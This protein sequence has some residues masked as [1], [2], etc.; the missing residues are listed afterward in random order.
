MTFR[1]MSAVIQIKPEEG[2]D[3]DEEGTYILNSLAIKNFSEMW[4]LSII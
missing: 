2:I 1:M 4:N 3:H